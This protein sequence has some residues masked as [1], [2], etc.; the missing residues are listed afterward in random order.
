M[1][2]KCFTKNVA[3]LLVNLTRIRKKIQYLVNQVSHLNNENEDKNTIIA[4]LNNK[5][6]KLEKLN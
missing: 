4:E 5:I 6:H 2:T 1:E 3:L